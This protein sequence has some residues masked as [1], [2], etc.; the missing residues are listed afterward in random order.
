MKIGLS[1]T[2]DDIKHQNYTEWLAEGGVDVIKLYEKENDPKE[3]EEYDALVLSGGIDIHPEFYNSGNTVYPHAPKKFYE[4]R[5]EFEIALFK[6]SQQAN[7][8]VLGICRGLQL[9][10]CF[11]NGTLVQDLG[12]EKN[13][14]HKAAVV[15]HIQK[16][17][18][19]GVDIESGTILYEILN[20][21]RFAANSAHHQAIDKLGTGLKANCYSD[22]GLIEGIE[23]EKAGQKPFLLG[24]QWHPERMYKFGLEKSPLSKAIRSRFIE[25]IKKSISVK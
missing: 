25:E 8:P 24:V 20:G 19:H 11:Y 23:W 1:Y 10:N 5:D 2:D 22:D 12:Q 15:N 3:I 9:I 16:D 13:N 6:Y 17:K 14:I 18:V 4:K 7:K 21:E